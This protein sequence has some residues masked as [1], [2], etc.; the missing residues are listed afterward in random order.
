MSQLKPYFC[1]FWYGTSFVF[2]PLPQ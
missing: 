1:E 2:Q